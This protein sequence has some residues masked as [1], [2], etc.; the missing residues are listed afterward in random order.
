MRHVPDIRL[1]LI[2]TG[3]LDDAGLDS[4]FASGKLKLTKGSLIM[5][6][7]RKKGSLY[8]AQAKLFKKEVNI[9]S[10]DMDIWHQR[11]GH[12]SEKCLNIISRKKLL[13]GIK[14][15][16]LTPCHDCLAGKT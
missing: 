9:A 16:S 12:M 15:R 10:D 11:L 1:I 7:G 14:G 5:A 4:N 13:P 8:V 3:K 2:S 6:R